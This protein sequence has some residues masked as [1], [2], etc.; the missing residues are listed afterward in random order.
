MP[1][2]VLVDVVRSPMGRGKP[3]GALA[4]VHPVELLAQ[5]LQTLVSRTGIDPGDVDDVIMGCVGQVGEQAATP[6]RMAWLSA[7]FPI[8]VPSTTVE[9]RCGSGQQAIDF[10]VQGVMAGA[11][12]IVIAGGVESMSHV[13]IGS[14]RLGRDPEGP[15]VHA[16]FP[17]LV[18][19]GVAAELIADKY[20]FSRTDLDE[21][22]AE[23]HVRA[24]RARSA[25]L[26][27]PYIVPITRPD[28]AV[29][30]TDE[31]IRPGTTVDKLAGLRPAFASDEMRATFPA[32]D[33]KITAGNS[34][35]VTD[36][37]GAVLIMSEERASQLGLQPRARVVA[38]S[39]TGS[40]PVLMLTGVIPAT[41]KVLARSKMSIDTMDQVEVNEAFA[42]VPLAWLSEFSIDRG[43]LNSLGGAIALGH[44]LGASGI[45][46][47]SSLLASLEA[48]GGRYGLQTLCEA[49]GMANAMI[50][51]RL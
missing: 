41:H 24:D 3:D 30:E 22:S 31:G 15:G 9:R 49:G 4:P 1:N 32:L 36:G 46:L 51:E 8:S 17:G 13:P 35:Q 26:F 5:V 16:R 44:P 20:G 7:G 6:G 47:L 19:Q 27:E 25:G 29:V 23:S 45:R 43:R 48:E 50:I 39:V 10:A 12:D 11:Y 33:W 40:D 42:P 21:L 37:A 2:A 38:S 14:H 28:G 18:P 34:S